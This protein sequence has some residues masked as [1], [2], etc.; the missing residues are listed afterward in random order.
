MSESLITE[1]Q[2]ETTQVEQTEAASGEP[3]SSLP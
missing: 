2:P 3:P 1:G